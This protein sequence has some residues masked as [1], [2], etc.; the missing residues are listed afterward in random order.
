[1]AKV[2]NNTFKKRSPN[3]VRHVLSFT[4]DAINT[5][6][7]SAHWSYVSC[8]RDLACVSCMLWFIFLFK[9]KPV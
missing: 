6:I 3:P 7:R 8:V 9:P 4:H 5:M 2:T 1:M